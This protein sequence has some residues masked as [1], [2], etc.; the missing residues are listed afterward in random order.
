VQQRVVLA[1]VQLA[2]EHAE[3][4]HAQEVAAAH[5]SDDHAEDVPPLV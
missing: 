3:R 2:H 5:E 4:V 1:V